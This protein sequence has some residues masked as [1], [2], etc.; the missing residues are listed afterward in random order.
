MRAALAFAF[1]LIALPALAQTAQSG[2]GFSSVGGTCSAQTWAYVG[3]GSVI[4]KREHLLP[5]VRY[6]GVPSR[7]VGQETD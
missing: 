3:A 7:A 5:R 1:A 4:M 2:G 6:Q